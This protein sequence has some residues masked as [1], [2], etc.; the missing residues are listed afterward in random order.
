MSDATG[1]ARLS[2]EQLVDLCNEADAP[3]AE[4]AF[5][6]LYER[7]KPFVLRV[8]SGVTHD[9]SLALDAMQETFAYVLRQFPP[10]PGLTLTAKLT[11]YLYPIARNSAISELRK[12]KRLAAD[13]EPDLLPASGDNDDD[14][15]IQVL[16]E[17]PPAGREVVTMRFVH[18]MSLAEIAEALDVKPGTV[19]SRLHTAI[20]HLRNSL[21]IKQFFDK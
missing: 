7:H 14:D 1:F 3:S 8:A 13:V 18:G 5:L 10:G 16:R 9:N 6:V 19:K 2:D 21:K 17:L 15:L 20:Q 11:S 4:Q 12:A